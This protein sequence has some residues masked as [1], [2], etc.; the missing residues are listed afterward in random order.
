MRLFEEKEIEEKEKLNKTEKESD[1]IKEI[2]RYK[3]SYQ[4]D[5]LPI[6]ELEEAISNEAEVKIN[7]RRIK[8][9][10]EVLKST[11]KKI[12]NLFSSTKKYP[13]NKKKSVYVEKSYALKKKKKFVWLP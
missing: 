12:K 1:K 2:A 5:I 7:K 9:A 8:N 6:K 11:Y 13:V 4:E 10:L 3:Y